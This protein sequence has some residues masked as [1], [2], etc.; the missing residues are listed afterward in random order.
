MERE[1]E[2]HR[3]GLVL[4][5]T[6]VGRGSLA[7]VQGPAGIGKTRLLD[8]MCGLAA[9][10]GFE[11]L[12]GR[13][14]DLE[15]EFPFGVVRQ[16]FEEQIVGAA[17]GARAELLGGLAAFA[18][19]VFTPFDRDGDGN[20]VADR[21]A[22]VVHGLYWLTCNLA[23]IRPVLLAVDDAHWADSPSLQF[24]DYL[25]RRMQRLPVAL[26][27]TNRPGESGPE[28]GLAWRIANDG[29]V[30][31]LRELTPDA[32]AA[33][34]RSVL[35]D[36][37]GSDLCDACYAAT[38]GNPM[39]VRELAL[40]LAADD[41]PRLSATHVRRLVPEAVARHVLVRL[42][43]LGAASIMAARAVAVLGGGVELRQVAAMAE[44]GE[45]NAADAVDA[46]V[47]ADILAGGGRLEFAHPLLREVVYQDLGA[48]E[49]LR[50]HARAARLLAASAAAP[51]RVAAQLLASEPRRSEW[52]V[53]ALRAA[54]AD[55]T[56]RGAADVAARYL[57]RALDERVE[58]S[59]QTQLLLELGVAESRTAQP[60]A[61]AHFADALRL[62]TGPRERATVAQQL[63]ALY[64][65]LGRFTESASLLE[66]TIDVAGAL[67][68][69][70]RFNLAAEAAVL[71]ITH[72]EARRRLATLIDEL[73]ASL[74]AVVDEPAAAPL[75]AVMAQEMALTDGT[76]EQIIGYAECA[77]ADGRL[78]SREG[79][80]PAVGIAALA[81]ADRPVRA[82]ALL[83]AVIFE[84]RSRGSIQALWIGLVGRAFARLRRGRM[85]ETEADA[86]LALELS[87]HGPSVAAEP[88][89]LACLAETLIE[90]GRFAES[91]RLLT[92]PEM[93]RHDPDSMLL[94]PLFDAR[95]R[96]LL[97]RGRA[98]EAS[99]QLDAQLRWQR[100]WGCRNP[101]WTSTRTLAA[102]AANA[103][104]NS[105]RACALAT[106]EL[107]AIAFGSP[108]A[109]GFA[110]RTMALVG[111]VDQVEYMRESAG[112]LERSESKLELARSLLELGSALR[113]R[114]ARREARDPLRRGLDLAL[115]CG[116]TLTADR[117]KSELLAAGARP[118][119]QRV[120]GPEALTASERR[121]ASMANEGLTNREIAQTLFLSLKT[122]EMHLG[123]VYQKLAV[124]SR[125][126][127][128][129]ALH[130]EN[131]G[132]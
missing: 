122:V 36:G 123:H 132:T 124:R 28:A 92:P 120:T 53:Q 30:I 110:F 22:A 16:L 14:S 86:R 87:S 39:L 76:T 93:A 108:R 82:E 52:A 37:A 13:G 85:A 26:V 89:I 127:L 24:M 95:A 100:D 4:E 20:G 10:R 29:A 102:L 125:A 69:E 111:A 130:S 90:Q 15:R 12:T 45:A 59:E 5:Q 75:L 41:A 2:L 19:P 117:A 78:L 84:A 58:G 38:G 18:E 60:Q 33:L 40:A 77:I 121:I 70:R 56:T 64:N 131:I 3:L 119:R 94:Q 71:G 73:R 79:P 83:D 113:R 23:A 25:A 81:M 44:L 46:L 61:V 55:A 106:E 62:S 9:G 129:S 115:A 126:Q 128:A 63:A 43:R 49:R 32:T 47:S 97:L 51:E 112:V 67:D 107:D 66:D 17:P 50:A 114:G 54:A 48:G 80:V 27:L 101:G 103:L 35:G 8:A 65:L 104:G 42:S 105:E 57:R 91:E 1:A 31:E 118:R 68:P 72:R 88:L 96:L 74:P 34:V 99:S 109:L 98:D 6:Q 7:F 21:S 116:S 11:M